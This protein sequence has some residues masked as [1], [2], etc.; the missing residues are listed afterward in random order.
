MAPKTANCINFPDSFSA[1]VNFSAS[2][3][4]P[5]FDA[6]VWDVTAFMRGVGSIDLEAVGSG[7]QYTFSANAATTADWAP[8]SYWISI[9]ATNGTD[10]V[11]VSRIQMAVTP[12]MAAAG[13]GYDGR[14]QAAIALDA[15]DAVI[16]RRATIDQQRYVINNRELWRMTV[17]DLLKLRSFYSSLVAR[18]RARAKGSNVFGRRINVRFS[19]Q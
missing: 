7:T 5:G 12:D 2:A 19:S 11:E 16:A 3:V 18:E 15:L 14:S 10:V 9:R 8:G 4:L 13:A 6:S 17:T 1:G